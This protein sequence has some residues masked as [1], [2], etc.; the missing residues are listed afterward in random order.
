MQ[1]QNINKIL[2]VTLVALVVVLCVQ[3]WPEHQYHGDPVLKWDST[4]QSLPIDYSYI[5]GSTIQG[6]V[7]VVDKE[8]YYL[9]QMVCD[10]TITTPFSNLC[11]NAPSDYK[12][13]M[14]WGY[15]SKGLM[16]NPE[17]LPNE[18]GVSHMHIVEKNEYAESGHF[19]IEYHFDKK[20]H[21]SNPISIEY[22]DQ[23]DIQ[24][25]WEM[26]TP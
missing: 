10:Y 17:V 18:D 13:A 3:N 6:H 20:T 14:F 8:D 22:T 23:N 5:D 11:V 25:R 26:T 24:H 7:Y 1:T 16:N 4:E 19:N 12:I 9:L 21:I 15:N 2:I